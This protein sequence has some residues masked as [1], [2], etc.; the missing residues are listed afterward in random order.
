MIIMLA[1][2]FFGKYDAVNNPNGIVYQDVLGM[3]MGLLLATIIISLFFGSIA[4][5]IST[6]ASKI[7]IMISTIGVAIVFNVIYML[8]P[9]LSITPNEYINN[10]YAVQLT[11]SRYVG[12]D[13]QMHDAVTS[14]HVI[15]T[16]N[17]HD[18]TT[19]NWNTLRYINNGSAH[20]TG[21]IISYI[22]IAQQLSSLFHAF[23]GSTSSEHSAYGTQFN[24]RYWLPQQKSI[25]SNPDINSRP[26]I[27]WYINET[28]GIR[29]V[30]WFI[31][32][33]NLDVLDIYAIVGSTADSFFYTRPIDR[34]LLSITTTKF[35]G[36]TDFMKFPNQSAYEK[37]RQYVD[38]LEK[39]D[40]NSDGEW[41]GYNKN[42]VSGVDPYG[43][44]GFLKLRAQFA[45]DLFENKDTLIYYNNPDFPLPHKVRPN[46]IKYNDAMNA[47]FFTIYY[48]LF[49]DLETQL[50]KDIDQALENYSPN[51]GLPPFNTWTDKSSDPNSIVKRLAGDDEFIE[52]PFLLSLR[53]AESSLNG[54]SEDGEIIKEQLIFDY[55]N[56]SYA[57]STF[58]SDTKN[59]Q[60]YVNANYILQ[61][62]YT[63]YDSSDIFSSTYAYQQK[64]YYN[65]ADL[66]IVWACFALITFG[67][68]ALIYARTDIK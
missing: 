40:L 14:N 25:F 38:S 29:T 36:T 18:D 61:K 3:E 63:S 33:V 28:E 10:N 11:S 32:S 27:Y 8:V 60:N 51:S 24:H 44:K 68:T 13:G 43:S 42:A 16:T 49:Q 48:M 52:D 20:A 62:T 30:R 57:F 17:D 6:I 23:D 2:F 37:T 15:Y 64:A 1:V 34:N 65:S 56:P 67:I 5:L 41:Y 39:S 26:W 55:R 31:I 59:N 47:D 19:N 50:W 53:Q 22:N 21:A 45:Q 58:K 7:I 46:D 54:K 4:I 35:Y 9:I 66:T 12:I